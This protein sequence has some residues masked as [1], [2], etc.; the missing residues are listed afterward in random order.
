MKE[1]K[2]TPKKVHVK[3]GD[4]VVL[5]TG[6]Y[7]DKFTKTGKPRQGKVLEVSRKEGKVIVEGINMI[8]KHQKPNMANRSGGIYIAEGA[9]YACKVQLVCPKCGKQTRVG[10]ALDK[11]GKKLRQC[12]KCQATF[13]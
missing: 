5:L 7:E 10:H 8:T 1:T 4:T 11:D 9:F 12:K 3:K 13:E 2:N 6:K